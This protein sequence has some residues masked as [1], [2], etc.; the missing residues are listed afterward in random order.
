MLS[1]YRVL[2]LTDEKGLLCG[3]I[4]G[5]LGADVIKIERPG[6]D[7]ARN[8]GPFYH[9]EVD[10]EKSLFWWAFNTSKRGIT[11]D[12]EAAEGQETF[13]KLVKSADFVIESFPPGYLDRLGLGYSALEELNPG[14]ILVSITPFGQTGPYKDYKAPDIVVWAMGGQMYPWG[15]VDRTPV[16]VSH[17]SQ[18]CLHAGAEAAAGAMLALYYREMTGEGQQVDVSIQD[19]VVRQTTYTILPSWDMM[20]IVQPRMGRSPAMPVRGTW[21]CK[22]GYVSWLYFFGP[23]ARRFNLPFVRWMEDEGMANDFLKG[24]DWDTY[25]LATTAQEILDQ[26]AEVPARYFLAHTKAELLE[27]AVKHGVMLYP[28]ATIAETLASVQLAARGFWM[29]LE[30]PELG[31]SVTYPGA[32]AKT[33]EVPPRVSRRAPLIGEHNQEIFE[34]ALGTPMEKL[35]TLKQDKDYSANANKYRKRN[36]KQKLLE[37]IKIAD[38]TGVIVGPLTTKM[39][40]DY[41]AKVI[42]IEGRSRPD[43]IRTLGPFKDGIPGLDR[44]GGFNLYNTSKLSVALN[45][46]HP[47]GVEI[48]KRFVAWADIV[49]ENFAGGAMERIGLGYEELKK[50]KPDIIMFSSCMQGQTGPYAS[51]PGFGTQLTALAGFSHIAGWPD[52][53]PAGYLGVYT[54]YITPHFCVPTLLAALDY[55]RR[56][57]RGQYIDISQYET[58]VHFMAPLVLDYVLNQRIANRMGNRSSDAAPHGVYRCRGEDR[59]CAIAAFADEEWQSFCQVI[60]NPVWTKDPKFTTLPARKENEDELDRLVEEWTINYSAEEVMTMMQV[61][62]V[63]AGVVETSQDLLEHDPQLKHRHFIRELDHPEVGKYYA[64]G[65]AFALS[66]CPCEPSSAPLVGEHNE[67]VLKEVIGMSDEEISELVIDGVVE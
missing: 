43:F 4:L 37:G 34:Q 1:S 53:E 41:G 7:P 38:F 3:K 65:P 30:H 19:S 49:A 60:G 58:G 50:V 44:S 6:G 42:R 23:Y 40:S 66:K 61:A 56:T 13:K 35:P 14:I 52:R 32:F 45:L 5:D 17:H 8:I 67:Y 33:S 11:L 64:P 59:W 24:F 57:G 39:F 15:D 10:P 51:H 46:A 31:T 22:D 54:D 29:K 62:G 28:V 16:R 9:D 48:A 55:R 18:A 21:P 20:K 27:G 25:D 47:K 63:A 2:D 26:L 36:M 12:I